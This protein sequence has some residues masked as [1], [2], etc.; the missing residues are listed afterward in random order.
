MEKMKTTCYEL[1]LEKIPTELCNLC[2]R[3][4]QLAEPVPC[5]RIREI[6]EDRPAWWETGGKNVFD[7]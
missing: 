4:K 5:L 1:R 7:R 6:E 2:P 3:L